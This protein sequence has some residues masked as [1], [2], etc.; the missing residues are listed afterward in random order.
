MLLPLC[1]ILAAWRA[2]T[3]SRTQH[4]AH[5]T[6]GL[7]SMKGWCEWPQVFHRLLSR[8]LFQSVAAHAYGEG[9]SS[10]P[11]PPS[12]PLIRTWNACPVM[13]GRGEETE[14]DAVVAR[15]SGGNLPRH[16][17]QQAGHCICAD[18]LAPRPVAVPG[19]RAASHALPGH[20]PSRPHLRLHSRP[21]GL[22]CRPGQ[23]AAPPPHF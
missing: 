13:G 23:P 22:A 9:A 1:H 17:L 4:C 14:T 5:S 6:A 10:R 21:T 12:G 15:N 20:R 19:P 2:P 7:A 18:R 3:G 16:V 8:P 11:L